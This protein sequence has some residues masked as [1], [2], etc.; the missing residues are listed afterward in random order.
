MADPLSISASIA[1]LVALADL[2][3][4]SGTKYA[5]GYKGAQR[6]VESLM[7]EVRG[8]SVVLHNLELVAFDLE[9]AEPSDQNAHQEKPSLQLHHLHDCRQLLRRMENGLSLTDSS[10]KSKS[11]LERIQAPLAAD[12][13]AKLNVCLSQ[14]T[15]IKDKL[16]GVQQTVEKILDIQVKIALDAKRDRILKDFGKVNPRQEY[17]T[18]R[19]LRHGL[20]GL[21]LTQGDEFNDWYSTPRAKLWCSGIPGGGKSV[22][23][24]A[25]VEECLQRNGKDPDKAVAY[26]FCTYRQP[27]SQDPH[28]ILSSL[29]M[30]L[31]LQNE[32]AFEILQEAHR[33]L[34]DGYFNTQPAPERLAEALQRIS[35]CFTRVYLVVDGL[36]ECGD[37]AEENTAA[38][39]QIAAIQQHDAINMALLSRDEVVIRH[40]IEKDFEH[41]EIEARTEDVQLYVASELSERI[42]TRKLRLKDPTLKDLIMTRLVEGAK[43][44]FRWVACQLDY[45]CELPTDKGR[46][47]AL[48]K[49][50]PTLFATYD[51]I[52]MKVEE[53]N[54]EV[55]ELVRKTLLLL[56]DAPPTSSRL[57][58]ESISLHED[59]DS[60]EEDEIV[61]EEDVLRWCSSL[62]RTK[63]VSIQGRST[64]MIEFAHFT[65]REYL[66]ALHTKP[67]GCQYPQLK[68]YAIPADKGHVFRTYVYLRFLTLDDLDRKLQACGLA[69][70][71]SGI[72]TE[73]KI[74]E[75]YRRGVRYWRM[76]KGMTLGGQNYQ[77]AQKL[78]LRKTPLFCLWAVEFIVQLR[79]LQIESRGERPNFSELAQLAI[80]TVLR[81]DFITLHMAVA[82]YV[83][84]ICQELLQ[85][86]SSP[87]VCSNFGSPL[88]Y[89]VA[90]WAIFRDRSPTFEI[91]PPPIPL[92]PSTQQLRTMELLLPAKIIFQSDMHTPFFP[93][94]LLSFTLS[95]FQR[96][97]LVIKIATLLVNAHVNIRDCDVRMFEK[98][99]RGSYV[100]HNL[101][102]SSELPKDLK[103]FV[104][105]LGDE[106]EPGTPRFILRQKTVN[107]IDKVWK[108]PS[109]HPGRSLPESAA[110]EEIQ[111]HIVSLI[112]LNDKQELEAFLATDDTGL[113][114]SLG[115][116]PENPS[117]TAL[118]LA[119]SMRSLDLIEPLLAFGLDPQ[120]K[121][122]DDETPIHL[123][124]GPQSWQALATGVAKQ[125][126]IVQL[127]TAPSRF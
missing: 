70:A 99:Y 28:S 30:Q 66:D 95:I 89:A 87:D 26:F 12:S 88:H 55:K 57:L 43:G 53:H 122:L 118:H 124:D 76:E 74:Y 121:A 4:R 83:P 7:R 71:I 106:H 113:I 36:D 47:Q 77:L 50:P 127:K 3:F 98:F 5:K 56:F 34:Y 49:L 13:L 29:C 51:R 8:L 82:L 68:Q 92:A 123:C 60:L 39:A 10:L 104:E 84:D 40:I 27:L 117:C 42:T 18:N 73:R 101:H 69:Q 103:R 110:T 25:I 6:E 105:V 31:A 93:D 54:D 94:N 52:L 37:H 22:L 102:P 100:A 126:G 67:I 78:L 61:S 2:I 45:M 91:W 58:C 109:A 64:T 65:V 81:S 79:S 1:G 33:E 19:K 114:R 11:G 21:W 41:I 120:A 16:D 35:S 111:E 108:A 24:A 63:D 72:V 44:M 46:R 75:T 14:Q 97:D 15:E 48:S 20:T 125:Y 107:I 80:S 85:E 119:V 86:G 112:S 90:G 116:D 32:E 59:A 115:L 62:L 38:L 96:P 17:E 23:A 9:E